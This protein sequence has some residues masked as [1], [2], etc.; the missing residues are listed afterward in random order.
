[1]LNVNSKESNIENIDMKSLDEELGDE[2]SL[3]IST[4]TEL[5]KA[6]S[7]HSTCDNFLVSPYW[8][9]DKRLQNGETDFLS[10]DEEVFWRK[11]IKKYLY[12]LDSN[13]Q[14]QVCT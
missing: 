2:N 13:K 9:Q 3:T 11:L 4:E 12:P 10:T 14:E 5:S 8:L 6:Y 1:M 7:S